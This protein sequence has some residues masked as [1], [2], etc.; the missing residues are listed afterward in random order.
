[1]LTLNHFL[2]LSA[3][4]FTIGASAVLL[5]RNAILVLM[6]I[7]LMLNAANLNLAAFARFAP[8]PDLS[9]Q[10]FPVFIIAVAAGEVAIGLAI[11]IALY[12]NKDTVNVDEFNLLKG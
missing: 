9:G 7:E 1:M 4:L 6:G 10:V 12:R 3:F 5:R 2:W 11:V 8:K